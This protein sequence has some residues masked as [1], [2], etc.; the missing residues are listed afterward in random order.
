MSRG[1]MF[2]GLRMEKTDKTLAEMQVQR[3]PLG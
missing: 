2:G 3:T 1:S